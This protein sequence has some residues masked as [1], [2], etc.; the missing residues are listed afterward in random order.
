[1]AFRE[2]ARKPASGSI[3]YGPFPIRLGRLGL[4][5]V[6]FLVAPLLAL[7]ALERDRLVCTPGARCV[8]THTIASRTRAFPMAAL[9][10][11]RADI[12]RGSKG[13]KNGVVVLVLDGGR[14][15]RLMQ[16]TP[17]RAGEAAAAIR[18]G[19]AGQRRIDVTLSGPWWMLLLSIGLLVFGLTMAYPSFKG[20]GRFRIDVT[21]GG[22]GLR[23]RRHLL[24]LPVSSRE[25]SLEGVTEVRVEAGVVREVGL[26][27]G[28]APMPAGR[29]VLVDRAGATRPLTAAALP[30]QAVHLR[31]ASELRALL[32]LERRPH[33]VEEQLAS[34]PPLTTPP[35]VRVA[36]AWIGL[37]VGALV[38]IGLFGLSGMALGL[39][40]ASG[41][42]EG[43]HLAVGGGGGAI[44]GVALAL[45]LTRERPP[46]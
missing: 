5:L 8:V 10:D 39:L 17:E 11:A 20:L 2:P 6:M 30:G 44:V 40:R 16:V 1:M 14:E 46:P 29:I 25:V 42:L 28:E 19:L 12:V 13:G 24:A 35:G 36:H 32:G 33:G 31:A 45:R 38:G 41:P 26:G 37:A 22:A 27:K 34:L 9:R 18:A 21:H 43:W 15:L 3:H 7:V 23:V 4:F